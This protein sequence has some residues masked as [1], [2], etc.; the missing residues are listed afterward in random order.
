MSFEDLI[1]EGCIWK[2]YMHYF[3]SIEHGLDLCR[4]QRGWKVWKKYEQFF[5]L[6]K[7]I[8]VQLEYPDSK[9]TP[10]YLGHVNVILVHKNNFFSILKRHSQDFKQVIGEN[11]NPHE[12]LKNAFKGKSLSSL[13]KRI[14]RHSALLGIL[15]GYGRENA[16]HFYEL[17]KL[18]S[19]MRKDLSYREA[20]EVAQKRIAPFCNHNYDLQ[21]PICFPMFMCLP[22]SKETKEL[23]QKYT[24]QHRKIC[25]IYR[26]GDFLE[27]TLLKLTEE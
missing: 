21:Y 25:E 17:S 14:K 4:Y 5:P 22:E 9:H 20:F 26:S 16:W 2:H 13:D 11:F 8:F 15:L 24:R 1:K 3:T 27:I 19:K 18:R 10:A 12:M 6:K 7:F 23:K